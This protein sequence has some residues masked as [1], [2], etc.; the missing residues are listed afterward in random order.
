MGV[1]RESDEAP[2]P[3]PT[4]FPSRW[5]KPST[6][7]TLK[8]FATA[9][10]TA[11]DKA[12]ALHPTPGTRPFQRLTRD[13]YANSVRDLLGIEVDVAK[14]LPPDSLSDGLDNIADSQAFSPA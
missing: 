5:Q 12:A 4:P 11:L 10:E 7:E 13:E 9:M 3:Y 1:C 6:F 8:A 2:P 14:F